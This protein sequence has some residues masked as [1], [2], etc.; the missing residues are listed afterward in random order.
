MGTDRFKKTMEKWGSKEIVRYSTDYKDQIVTPTYVARSKP[1]KPI[2]SPIKIKS[3]NETYMDKVSNYKIPLTLGGL[4]KSKDTPTWEKALRSPFA[5]ISSVNEKFNSTPLGSNFQAGLGGETLRGNPYQPVEGGN[6]IANSFAH[7]AGGLGKM[8]LIG[9]S[10]GLGFGG[11]ENAVNTTLLRNT[12]KGIE[13]LPRLAQYGIKAG[14]TGSEMGYFSGVDTA[15]QGGNLKDIG[16][17]AAMG[18]GTG[19]A[20][21]VGIKGIGD[22]FKIPNKISKFNKGI[23]QNAYDTKFGKFEP[24]NENILNPKGLKATRT[25]LKPVIKP[26]IETK[27]TVKSVLKPKSDKLSLAMSK[28]KPKTFT[29]IKP[30]KEFKVPLDGNG[31]PL[32]DPKIV[33]STKADKTTFKQKLSK[34]YTSTVDKNNQVSKFSKAAGDKTYIKATNSAN[35]KNIA[36]YNM[37]ENMV[38]RKGEVIGKSLKETLK[39]F[40][41]ETMNYAL[42]KHNIARAREGKPI[43]PNRNSEQSAAKVLEMERNNPNLKAKSSEVTKWINDFMEEWGVKSG[44]LDKGLSK[45]NKITYPDYIPTNRDLSTLESLGRGGGGNKGYV[46]QTIP[47]KRATGSSKDIID[48]KENIANLVTRTI[49]TAKNNEVGQSMAESI[50]KNPSKLKQFAEIVSEPSDKSNVVRVL[51][52]GKPTYI[53]INDIE[54]LKAMEQLNKSDV[55]AV[56]AVAKSV[57][58]AFKQLITQKNPVFAIR[59]IAR[60]VPTAYVNGSEANPLKFAWDLAKSTKDIL[61]NTAEYKQYKGIGGGGSNFIASN[62]NAKIA[63]ALIGNQS[64]ITKTLKSIPNGIESFNNVTESVPRFAEFKRVLKKTGSLDEALFAANDVTTNFSRGG[65]TTKFI[66]SF[67]PY[68]NAGVQGLDKLARQ[69]K[70]KPLQTLAKGGVAITAPTLI[71][72]KLNSKD[73]N[74][75]ALDNRTKDNYF[76]FPDLNKDGKFIKIPKS[77]ELGVLFSSLEERLLRANK[78]EKGSFKGFG[79]TVATNFSPANPIENNILAPAFINLPRNKDFANRPIVPMGMTKKM[80]DNRSPYLQSDERSTEISKWF[81]NK[82]KDLPIIPDALKSPKKLDYLVRSYSGVLGQ[83]G[84]PANTKSLDKLNPLQKALK[85]IARQ[86]TADS[87]YN[88]KSIN[89]FYDNMDK[90][91]RIATNKN[92]NGNIDSKIVTNEEA[93]RNLF[94]RASTQIT[95]INKEIKRT[96]N[97]DTIKRLKAQAIRIAEEANNMVDSYVEGKSPNRS[98]KSATK[99]NFKKTMDKWK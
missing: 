26:T 87:Q 66:D 1:I 41:D 89:D 55:K 43:F 21:S 58:G 82:V 88:N 94:T 15:L 49:K 4:M 5:A 85:P 95:E 14:T 13:A 70:N 69:V 90:L 64:K 29:K 67:V 45:A 8:S 12:S 86:F 46:N 22:G 92:I 28:E 9:G 50:R 75:Q 60:D 47:I 51:E 54:L 83:M 97:S 74:Y 93:K 30:P 53:K 65:Q 68:T 57:T 20:F 77:R 18:F 99:S 78:G 48:P 37:T 25:N 42:E 16:K 63:K 79:N 59:N 24:T 2:L 35:Q 98:S 3:K 33:S 96:S 7:G 44:T 81:A 56:E 76:M 62:D 73:K 34:L 91:K 71:L 27:P 52:G 17:S 72:N 61:K 19:A 84:Q 39:G 80:G 23:K 38:N 10:Q 40:D 32:R 31:N 11:A 36:D 6:G